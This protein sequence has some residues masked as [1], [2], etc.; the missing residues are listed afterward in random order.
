MEFLPLK[1]LRPNQFLPLAFFLI[2]VCF[3]CSCSGQI[4]IFN[5]DVA[6][7]TREINV[8]A[9]SSYQDVLEK[10]NGVGPTSQMFASQDVHVVSYSPRKE[11]GE[12]KEGVLESTIDIQGWSHEYGTMHFLMHIHA[13]EESTVIDVGLIQSIDKLRGQYYRYIIRPFDDDTTQINIYH[14]LHIEIERRRL[15]F[16]NR[17]IERITYEKTNEKIDV[18]TPQMACRVSQIANQVIKPDPQESESESEPESDD[19]DSQ[20][21]PTS[22]EAPSD[23]QEAEP[24][25]E[26]TKAENVKAPLQV[27][28]SGAKAASGEMRIAIYNSQQ[29]YK[30][31]DS[32]KPE[33]EQGEVFRSKVIKVT[34]ANRASLTVSFDDIPDGTYAI[35][36]F[37]DVNGNRQL[38]TSGF[39]LP[40]EPYGF[41]RNARGMFGPPNYKDATIQ[42]GPNNNKFDFKIK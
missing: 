2:G 31:N 22:K 37:H 35:G 8:T 34:E 13:T 41:S 10:M 17:I 4:Q 3:A 6:L 25:A 7:V 18:L 24:L 23:Q 32:T 20:G 26:D 36:A 33:A 12:Q 28:I 21:K 29:Q 27:V 1:R 42:F 39:G 19:Q 30:R 9:R 40:T 15:R 5:G 16:I 11:T 14:E 38:D